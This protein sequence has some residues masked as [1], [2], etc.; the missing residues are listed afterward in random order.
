MENDNNNSIDGEWNILIKRQD[1]MLTS[2]YYVLLF[3]ATF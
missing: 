1:D 2:T 3:R